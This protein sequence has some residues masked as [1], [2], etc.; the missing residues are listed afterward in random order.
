MFGNNLAK[1]E[2]CIKKRNVNALI[3]LSGS[4]KTEVAIA[5]I[6]GLGRCASD[7]AYNALIPFLR[8]SN[9]EKRAAAAYALGLLRRPAAGVHLRHLLDTEKDAQVIAEAKKAMLALQH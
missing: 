4:K 9:P 5:A 2:R 7:E 8:D 6:R 1:V 3:N